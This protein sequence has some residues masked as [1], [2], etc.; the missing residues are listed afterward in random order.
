MHKY[1]VELTAKEWNEYGQTG[2][3]IHQTAEQ[4]T[5]TA[6]YL[7]GVKHGDTTITYPNSSSIY[8]TKQFVNG[9]L[10]SIKTFAMSGLPVKFI[11]FLDN[12]LEKHLSYS[13][14][15]YPYLNELQ[16]GSKIIK[17]KY[18]RLDG[19]LES[20]VLFYTG[21]RL[22]RNF[23]GVLEERQQIENGFIIFSTKY[24][25]NGF[26]KTHAYYLE[27]KI[28][29]ICKT[30]S[31]SGQ[32]I[33]IESWKNDCLEGPTIY[34]QNGLRYRTCDY[35]SGE[36]DGVEIFYDD[37]GELPIQEIA[38]KHDLRHGA[39]RFYSNEEEITEWFWEGEPLTKFSFDEKMA[40]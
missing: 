39:S 17:G 26:P 21:S 30:F 37:A 13:K 5:V 8:E 36:K 24:Y 1:G 2:K 10:K 27:N 11:E 38:W 25:T 7:S 4:A 22:I 18:F 14:M 23:E 32:P 9:K 16:D 33:S 20:E 12:G 34:Y 29:G 35:H 19:S 15:G 28:H 6:S 3:I 40:N 31:Q